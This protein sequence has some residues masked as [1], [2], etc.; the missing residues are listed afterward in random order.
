MSSSTE[1]EQDVRKPARY[2]EYYERTVELTAAVILRQAA[3]WE[4]LSAGLVD[5]GK[6]WGEFERPFP[7][8]PDGA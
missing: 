3:G 5:D 4:L 6:I 2:V 7:D 8:I 1:P